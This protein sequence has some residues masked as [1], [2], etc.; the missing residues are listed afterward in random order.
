M[1]ISLTCSH[2]DEPLEAPEH[3]AGQLVRCPHCKALSTVPGPEV[4]LLPIPDEGEPPVTR[5]SPV[6]GR[7]TRGTAGHGSA[8][9]WRS[10]ARGC[11][12]VEWG[13]VTEF[14]AVTL[15]FMVVAGVGL[16]RLGVIPVARVNSDYSA[17]VFF[18]LL[19]VGTGCVCA[20][21][22]MMLQLPAG[23]S[24]LGV[25]MGAFCLSGLRF[26][27]LL[28]A[29]LF[30]AFALV[31]RGD[32]AVG[33]EWVGRLYALAAVAG[34]VAE[35]S[36]VA[37]MGVVGGALP[38]DRLRRRAGAVALA[39][40]LMVSAWVVLMALIIYAGLFAEFLPRPAP[41]PAARP[42]PPA[43]PIPVAQR[44]GLLLGGLLV[45]YLFNAAYSFIHYSLFAAGRAAAES[46]RS[47]SESAQ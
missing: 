23:T 24:G 34:F 4:E 39:L 26:L 33:T 36:V 6:P 43:A 14:L 27:A 19:L 5:K 7:R 46:N 9:P 45:V 20:G 37:G 41:V 22:L 44:A 13:I 29:L 38:T 2:C 11:R 32:R 31:S 30:V 40:Q 3:R 10:F 35:V 18:G 12:W 1:P 15:M 42:A 47:G 28:C 16:G 17:P 8:G 25:L 21:R